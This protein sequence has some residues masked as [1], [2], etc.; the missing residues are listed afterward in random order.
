VCLKVRVVFTN[1]SLLQRE[2]FLV[3]FIIK[4]NN[5]HMLVHN[6]RKQIFR[7]LFVDGCLINKANMNN[8]YLG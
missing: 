5:V 4:T 7:E 8:K 3:G 6:Q 1:V 2:A